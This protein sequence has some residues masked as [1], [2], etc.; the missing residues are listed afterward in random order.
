MNANQGREG[1]RGGGEGREGGGGREGER[2]RGER[3]TLGVLFSQSFLQ[4]VNVVP[5]DR[6]ITTIGGGRDRERRERASY[7]ISFIYKVQQIDYL[8][9]GY[10]NNWYSRY[11]SL[12]SQ[13]GC[14]DGSF[15]SSIQ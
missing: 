2:E 13:Y 1:E 7:H 10:N 15:C 14:N 8:P 4:K 12:C 6:I 9:C 11:Q 5:I 3:E